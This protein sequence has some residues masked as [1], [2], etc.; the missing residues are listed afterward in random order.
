MWNMQYIIILIIINATHIDICTDIICIVFLVDMHMCAKH[1]NRNCFYQSYQIKI[2]FCILIDLR[3]SIIMLIIIIMDYTRLDI[4]VGFPLF[5]GFI[6][7]TVTIIR[8][9]RGSFAKWENKYA[10]IQYRNLFSEIV[11]NVKVSLPCQL[12]A[13]RVVLYF[14]FVYS[15]CKNLEFW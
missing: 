10:Q 2:F 8:C 15:K 7:F 5:Y 14:F 4:Q 12:L 3:I 13:R 11:W 6:M 9:F 1:R